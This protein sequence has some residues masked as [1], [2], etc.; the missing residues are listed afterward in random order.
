GM[1][2][3]GDQHGLEAGRAQARARP[4]DAEESE[5][6]EEEP[7][8]GLEVARSLA[9]QPVE[10]RPAIETAV[11]GRGLR[12]LALALRGRGHLGRARADQIESQAG[13]RRESVAESHV[14]PLGHTV[15]GG[16]VLT[17]SPG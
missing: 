1:A 15:A 2:C 17:A 9:D 8:A 11:V 3:A 5:E 4:L 16:I 14:Y 7:S 6:G 12:I 10:E 13:H